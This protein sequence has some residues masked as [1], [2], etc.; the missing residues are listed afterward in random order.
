MNTYSKCSHYKVNW[1]IKWWGWT[2]WEDRV[3]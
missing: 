2:L 3:C 1:Y